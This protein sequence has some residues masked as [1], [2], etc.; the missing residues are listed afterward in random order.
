MNKDK[1]W[2]IHTYIG[3]TIGQFEALIFEC[4]ENNI[5]SHFAIEAQRNLKLLK[6]LIAANVKG[7]DLPSIHEKE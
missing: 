4:E 3:Q 7:M 6:F 5:P 1:L 2:L